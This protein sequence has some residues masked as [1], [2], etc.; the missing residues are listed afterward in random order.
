[1]NAFKEKEYITRTL[2][3]EQQAFACLVNH[4]KDK[5]FALAFRIMRQRELAEEVT[6]DI[7]VKVFQHL[8]SFKE[9]AAFSTWLYRIAYNTSISAI[10]KRKIV[11]Q[12]LDESFLLSLKDNS[13]ENET[14]ELI[15]KKLNELINAL[16]SEEAALITLFYHHD[17][18]MEEIGQITGQSLANIKVKIHRI[19]NK[20]RE[21]LKGALHYE[22]L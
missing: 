17:K 5:V 14:E 4:Y 15:M 22:T 1:M 9:N 2:Q 10:R 8:T 6:Q 11:G 12:P 20:L 13:E 16:P 21:Q 3:G 18:S 19:R 7:F